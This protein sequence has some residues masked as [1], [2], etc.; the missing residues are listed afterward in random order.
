MI[1]FTNRPKNMLMKRYD[2]LSTAVEFKAIK[3][4]RFDVIS[5][6]IIKNCV[7]IINYDEF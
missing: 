1:A 4:F 3:H 2:A 6:E 5:S 7:R